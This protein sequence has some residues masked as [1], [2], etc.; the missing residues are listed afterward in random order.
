MD[1]LHFITMVKCK[2]CGKR[3]YYK[4]SISIYCKDHKTIESRDIRH[5]EHGRQ[6]SKCKDCGGGSI[7]EHGRR[8]R[9]Q[10]KDCGG[11]SICEHGRIR[12]Q[13]K[14]CGGGSICEHGRRR[15]TCKECRGSQ[16]CE[17]GRQRSR[18]KEC[19]GVGICEHGRIR[20]ICKDCGGMG[21]CEHERVR[22]T[23]KECE[24]G[25]ICEHGRRRNQCKDCGGKGICEHE[26]QRNQCIICTPKNA[27]Q[28]CKYIYVAPRYRFKPYCFK[29]YCVLNPDVEI[30]R[31]YKTRE[32]HMRDALKEFFPSVEMVFDKKIE[33]GCSARRPDVLIDE[34]FPIII[35]CDENRHGGYSCENKRIMQL[36][37]DLG[38]RPVRFIR[39]N[40][41][42]YQTSG[43][44]YKGCFKSTPNGL[45][46]DKK[47]WNNRIK[48]LKDTVEKFL[49]EVPEKEITIEHLFFGDPV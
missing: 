42:S 15:N 24:G 6:K 29:C 39:F 21:I 9:S 12:S 27:C 2:S 32:Y 11:G 18:C 23:C 10:C 37:Q 31:R 44:R 38:N 17:H 45:S 5:C 34:G 25:S 4:D 13:C 14:E 49:S 7:C 33:C 36:F 47:E 22:H 28:H 41:D 16:I 3:A 30:P 8:R 20:H 43:V 48:I 1:D 19:G 26:R 35:E 40:P 46:I